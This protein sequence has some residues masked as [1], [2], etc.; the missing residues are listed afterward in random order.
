M[1]T[2]QSATAWGGTSTTTV[3]SVW[4]V[5]FG[6]N[7]LGQIVGHSSLDGADEL[8]TVWN[9]GVPTFRTPLAGY[10]RSDARGINNAGQIAGASNGTI[11][12][13]SATVWSGGG[14]TALALLPGYTSSIALAINGNGQVAGNSYIG[15]DGP[16][17]EMA[18]MWWASQVTALLPISG[19]DESVVRG[20]NDAGWVV[21]S[22]TNGPR[23]PGPTATLWKGATP[24]DLNTLLSDDAANL[25]W[26]L[27]SANAINNNE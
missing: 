3:G 21:G 11:G 2:G 25:G 5:A 13:S 15:T 16:Q 23:I 22:S 17:T 18:T 4:P 19:H 10:T 24:I 27:Y 6:V 20:M 9:E 14:A 8:A 1:H 7:S 12:I 26:V